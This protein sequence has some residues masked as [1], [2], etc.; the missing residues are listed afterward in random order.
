MDDAP[1]YSAEE[2]EAV[3]AVGDALRR[4][5]QLLPD[6]RPLVRLIKPA[7][8]PRVASAA[9]F[10]SGRMMVNP[11]WFLGLRLADRIFVAAHQ[12]MHLALGSHERCTGADARIANIA[13]D[14][15][16]N[17]LLRWALSLDVPAGGLDCFGMASYPLT[18]IVEAL[19]GRQAKGEEFADEPWAA[20][21]VVNDLPKTAPF[22]VFDALVERLWFPGE[23]SGG[24]SRAAAAVGAAARRAVE[25]GVLRERLD[26]SAATDGLESLLQRTLDARLET[27][28]RWALQRWLEEAAPPTRTFGRRS[29]RQ[30]G[31]D[32]FVLSGHHRTGW[33]LDLLVD[34]AAP[35]T[36][37]LGAVQEI[38]TAIAIDT[39]RIHYCGP[40]PM[41]E[42]VP[43]DELD[44]YAGR[45]GRGHLQTAL[46]RLAADE[47]VS[48]ALVISDSDE[49]GA[50]AT[51]PYPVLWICDAEGGQ[52]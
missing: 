1:L 34:T 29:R 3:D 31:D 6:L 50:V 45:G 16:I 51:L 24:R 28:W 10:A 2:A 15:A 9:I 26:P 38:G 33:T 7:P 17:D 36:P 40:R 43:L 52:P 37:F 41:A 39:V 18:K 27:D 19:R 12:L 11:G 20:P 30:G 35:V 4:A 14:Y 46:R 25:F 32:G 44:R 22:D 23:D 47:T 5:G 49:D 21:P 48:A 42:I 8:D 13:D